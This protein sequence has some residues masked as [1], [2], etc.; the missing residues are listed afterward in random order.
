MKKPERKST[1]SVK[2]KSKSPPSAT[3]AAKTPTILASPQPARPATKIKN[4]PTAPAPARAKP[5]TRPRAPRGKVLSQTADAKRARARRAAERA[6]A[7]TSA[8]RKKSEAARKRA[9]RQG[10]ADAKRAAELERKAK[11]NAADKRRRDA[12]RGKPAPAALREAM[13]EWLEHMRN[14]GAV[15]APL[16]F[17]IAED[18]RK[19]DKREKNEAGELV[20]QTGG[21]WQVVARFDLGAPVSY[22]QL[23]EIFALWQ[24]DLFLEASIGPSRLSQIRCW[25]NDPKS[26]RGEGDSVISWGPAPWLAMVGDALGELVGSG[27]DESGDSLAVRYE[28]TNVSFFYV[29][30]SASTRQYSTIFGGDSSP[31][32]FFGS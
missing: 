32:S 18:N 13:I 8:A 31:D 23:A 10:L 12:R 7:A 19:L 24:D 30:F 20:G 11:R 26:K 27:S 5:W 2:V 29:Y 6:A 16:S 1:P 9:E 3:T 28:A 14:T 15:V 4:K 21:L 22:A 17:E 25:F